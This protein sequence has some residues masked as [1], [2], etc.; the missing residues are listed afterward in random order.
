MSSAWALRKYLQTMGK[1]AGT[2]FLIE[3]LKNLK[4]INEFF[5][6]MKTR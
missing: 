2:E 3:R 1:A 6:A 4:T 5:K